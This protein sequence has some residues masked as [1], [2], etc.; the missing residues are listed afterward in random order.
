MSEAAKALLGKKPGEEAD[1]LGE[2]V[3]I[4]AIAPWR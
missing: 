3:R 4:S 2:R 1:F